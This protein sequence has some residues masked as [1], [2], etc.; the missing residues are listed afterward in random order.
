MSLSLLSSDM[1][2]MTKTTK[3]SLRVAIVSENNALIFDP[4]RKA[5]RID[6]FT[7]D[8]RKS[9]PIRF[10]TTFRAE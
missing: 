4:E 1:L 3:A 10:R 6:A 2:L 9:D 8:E 5:Y 7:R